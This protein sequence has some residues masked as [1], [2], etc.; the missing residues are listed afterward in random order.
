MLYKIFILFLCVGG[1]RWEGIIRIFW[2]F[3]VYFILHI[4]I[5]CVLG[6]IHTHLISLKST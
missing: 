4:L 6:G 2:C 5:V 1:G 3:S